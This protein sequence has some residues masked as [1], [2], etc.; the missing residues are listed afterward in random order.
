MAADASARTLGSV[1]ATGAE[2]HI[3]RGLLGALA[4]HGNTVWSTTRRDE[5]V[6]PRC[7]HLDLSHDSD[8]W[9]LPPAPID[10][11]FL[12]AAIGSQERCGM[13]PELTYRVNVAHTV[14]LAERLI[15]RGSFVVFISTNLVFDG[16]TP[17][18]KIDHPCNPSSA[19]GMQK[20]EAERRLLA[21]GGRVAIVRLGKVIVPGMPLITGWIE[22]LR[23]HGTIHPFDNLVMAPISLDFAVDVLCHVAAARHDGIIHATAAYDITYAHA[24]EIIAK[25]VGIREP[26]IAPISGEFSPYVAVPRHAALESTCLD[27]VGLSAPMPERA[28]DYLLA[29]GAQISGAD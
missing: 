10:V 14:E 15:E 25:L 8:A 2:G 24:A 18:A 28:F 3:A 29:A 4:G 19:Y 7:L 17:F 6:G 26:S 27:A 23:A 9:S 16:N 12:C 22:T 20:A 21:L 5:N 11:A 13:E 1:L